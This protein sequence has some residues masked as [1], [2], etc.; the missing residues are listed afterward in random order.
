MRTLRFVSAMVVLAPLLSSCATAYYKALE[1]VG[2]EKRDILVNRVEE[3]RDSQTEAK[4]QFTS[5]LDRYRSM[6]R[7]RLD[8]L[9]TEVARGT[10]ARRTD[11]GIEP[12]RRKDA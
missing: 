8:A 10:R 5:A 1:T 6:W 9:H 2:V 3:A 11:A 7:Q 12:A 4:E